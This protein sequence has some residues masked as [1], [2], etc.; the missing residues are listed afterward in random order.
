[1]TNAFEPILYLAI[2]GGIAALLHSIPMD[3]PSINVSPF[4]LFA[5]TVCVIVLGFLW[6]VWPYIGPMS[7]E[8]I[9][10]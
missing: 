1:M 8:L 4:K 3:G 5:L 2:V 6:S 7:R 10:R 9:C